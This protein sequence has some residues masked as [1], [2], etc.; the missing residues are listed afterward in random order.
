ML[1][2]L[3][4]ACAGLFLLFQVS[5]GL[6]QELALPEVRP[7]PGGGGDTRGDS[8]VR[9]GQPGVAPMGGFGDTWG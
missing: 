2:F 1:L 5:V 9:W 3:F 7:H 8:G 4:L 6:D